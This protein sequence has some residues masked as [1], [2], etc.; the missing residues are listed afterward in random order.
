M[1]EPRQRRDHEPDALLDLLA[2]REMARDLF[3][4]QRLLGRFEHAHH[5]DGL[6][7]FLAGRERRLHLPQ[8]VL[9]EKRA[10]LLRQP[11][12]LLFRAAALFFKAR[13][14]GVG[15]EARDLIIRAQPADLA[16]LLLDGALLVQRDKPFEDFLVRKRRGPAIGFEDERIEPLVQFLQDENEALILDALVFGGERLRPLSAFRARCTFA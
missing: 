16:G 8:I 11:V 12:L 7:Q 6:F 4:G 5:S 3:D 13:L 14:F 2:L 15:A 1:P 9:E 10:L